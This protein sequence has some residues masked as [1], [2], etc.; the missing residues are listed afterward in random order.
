[1][2]KSRAEYKRMSRWVL[3]NQQRLQASQMAENL[4]N[5]RSRDLWEE[6]RRVRRSGSG[7]PNVVDGAVGDE[8][9]CQVFFEKYQ[10]LYQS[11][12]TDPEEVADLQT[13][14]SQ[15]IGRSCATGMCYCNHEISASQ[16][17]TAVL[18]L[19][20]GKADVDS[21]LSSDCYRAAGDDLFVH[22]AL[23]LTA[24]IYHSGA[25]SVMSK[26]LLIPIP[27][28]AK[29]SINQSDNYRSIAISSVLGKCLDN[30][31]MEKHR[32]V[33][34]ADDLQFGFKKKHSTTLCTYVLNEVLDHYTQ[35]GSKVFVTMLDA[36]RAFD[37]VHYGKLFHL[38]MER[39]MCCSTIRLLLTMYTGQVLAVRWA[40]SVSNSFAC[41][42]G[43][44]QGGVLSPILFC[45]IIDVLLQR[46]RNSGVGCYI[47]STFVG[48]VSYADDVSL[49]TPSFRSAQ[50][51]LNICSTFADEFHLLFNGNKSH[52]LV[53][54]APAFPAKSL[55]L[56]GSTIPYA[57]SGLHLGHMIGANAAHLNAQRAIGALTVR[58]NMLAL[59][60][61]FV[62]FEHLRTLFRSYCSDL[63]GSQ[64]WALD[65]MD[66]VDVCWRKCARR[67]LK[68]NTRTHNRFLPLIAHQPNPMHACEKKLASFY[69]SLITSTNI[70]V[71]RCLSLSIY[72]NST[73]DEN[74]KTLLGRLRFDREL[75]DMH[76]LND[77]CRP[78][79]NTLNV[80]LPDDEIAVVDA[81]CDLM[82]FRDGQSESF[83][84][85][86]EINALLDY[87]C[88]N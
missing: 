12:P 61:R 7:H 87:L 9:V 19:K 20:P 71:Q 22:L 26:S 28:C 45:I 57:A 37:R 17:K 27:K 14:L 82:C 51:M 23:F 34:K 44:K 60:Y 65:E 54:G 2:L 18:R 25:S 62:Y 85:L 21:R 33:L 35:G 46:L 10:E 47:G 13:M 68:L 56:N 78:C 16:V 59:N 30:V 81:I 3:R 72:G 76:V 73:F 6:T 69:K 15:G 5:N 1:M 80:Q 48:A 79:L 4:A 70:I 36:S 24:S 67:V 38:L 84:S 50:I 58:S 86:D 31:I 88:T 63:Y 40:H 64:F 53:F 74:L 8:D 75:L 43:V 52:A 55:V 29:K 41:N 39:E 77:T 11:V 42:N 83:F 32:D 66:V 49:I